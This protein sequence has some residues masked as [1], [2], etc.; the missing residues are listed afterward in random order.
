MSIRPSVPE[1]I[2]VNSEPL[3]K[4]IRDLLPSQ[5]GFGSEL[6]ASNVITP[7]I[8]LTPTAEGSSLPQMLQTAMSFGGSTDFSLTTGQ[9]EVISTTG[10]WRITAQAEL[11]PTSASG[12]QARIKLSDGVSG[13]NVVNIA[14]F[15]EA[16]PSQISEFIDLVFFIPA[17][18]TIQIDAAVLS[19]WNGSYRQIADVTGNLID[20]VGFV[21]E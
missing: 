21:R 6:Q 9:S 3:Q 12:A 11:D 20:P 2:T 4:T 1:I 10:F 19:S 15:A 13:K 8:D 7:I 17:G 5:A 14:S 16:D 18:H